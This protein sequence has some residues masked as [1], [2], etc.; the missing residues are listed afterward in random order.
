MAFTYASVSPFSGTTTWIAPAR[1]SIPSA[2]RASASAT[3]SRGSTATGAAVPFRG[4][5][6]R[7]AG[8]ASELEP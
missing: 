4:G 6:P 1:G 3:A 2:W 7:P 8:V 5:V